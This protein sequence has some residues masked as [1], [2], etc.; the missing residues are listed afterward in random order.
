M[1][2]IDPVHNLFLGTSKKIIRIWLNE[3]VLDDEKLNILQDRVDRIDTPTNIGRIPRK[4]ATSFEGFTANQWMHWTNVFDI[5]LDQ[6]Y[7]P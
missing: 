1:S 5:C 7:P 2:K 6:C 3:G 4:I